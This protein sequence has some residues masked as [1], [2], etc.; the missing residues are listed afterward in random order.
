MWADQIRLIDNPHVNRR[1]C[2][3]GGAHLTYDSKIASKKFG[4]CLPSKDGRVLLVVPWLNSVI[5]G[6]TE[7]VFEEPVLNPKIS[8]E[9]KQFIQ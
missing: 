6:T 2:I 5:A 9:E 8:V 4:L 1:M 7:K 3:V